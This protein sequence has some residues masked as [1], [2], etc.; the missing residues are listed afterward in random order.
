MN[1][2][3]FKFKIRATL[4][5][6]AMFFS[7]IFF[8]NTGHVQA[9]K[10]NFTKGT[11]FSAGILSYRVIKVPGKNKHGEVEIIGFND[12]PGDDNYIYND[13]NEEDIDTAIYDIYE[14]LFTYGNYRVIGIADN[15]FKGNTNIRRFHW[16][17]PYFRYVGKSAF[18]GCSN[19]RY[20][21]IGCDDFT[22]IKGKAFYNCTSLKKIYLDGDAIKYIGKG[23]FKNT[24]S[25]I[26]IKAEILSTS[27]GTSKK[28][29]TKMKKLFKKAGVKKAK[30]KINYHSSYKTNKEA[31]YY[32]Y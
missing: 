16:S 23:A 22:K 12:N 2:K 15:A 31:D 14:D 20:F 11:E 9:K 29:I 17:E 5:A 3:R 10:Y 26:N 32:Y 24:C 21:G 19:L 27:D 13:Y 28:H 1:I 8:F 18:E 30:Y 25:N 4:F 6:F 7:I